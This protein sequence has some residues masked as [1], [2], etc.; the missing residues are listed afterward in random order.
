MVSDT[1]C[2]ADDFAVAADIDLTAA[3]GAIPG[4]LAVRPDVRVTAG[5]VQ[6]TAVSKADGHDRVLEVRVTSEDLAAVQG[7]RQLRWNEPFSAWLR[8]RRGAVTGEPFRVEEAR[9]ASPAVELS[10]AGTAENSSVQWTVDLDRLVQIRQA[11]R[12]V[13]AR[14]RAAHKIVIC[15]ARQTCKSSR[16]NTR[17]LP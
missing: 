15:A 12:T 10:V 3:A 6:F 13:A 7:E 8:G 5:Q 17:L 14:Q 4:G 2:H 16:C 1:G 11:Q 9:I